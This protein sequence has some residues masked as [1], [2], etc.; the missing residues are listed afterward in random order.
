MKFIWYILIF[1][2]SIFF[3]LITIEI[4]FSSQSLTL[5]TD[6]VTQQ[7]ISGREMVNVGV[8]DSVS[9]SIVRPRWY[10]TINEFTENE[11]QKSYLNPFNVNISIPYKKETLNYM[12]IHL[13]FIL[14]LISMLLVIK[15]KGGNNYETLDQ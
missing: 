7:Q 5:F 9:V 4:I 1:F 2:V 6:N 15:L 8:G 14:C 13:I 12:Y 10:G 11:I 3:Y